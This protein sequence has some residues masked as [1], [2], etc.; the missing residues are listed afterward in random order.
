MNFRIVVMFLFLT[1][2]VD[3]GADLVQKEVRYQHDGTVMHGFIV[4]DDAIKTKRP[5]VLVVH[6]W[7]GHNNYARDRAIQ[8]AELGYTAF[9]VDMYGDGKTT[10]HPKSASKF[11]SAVS[12][13]MDLAK[14]R[15]ESAL[16]SLKQQE[17]VDSNNIAALGYCFGGGILLNLA[18][19]GIDIKGIA[20]FHGSVSTKK[21]A[22]KR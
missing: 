12:G 7:W 13:N 19:M 15:F 2:A 1:A 8:L 18:R 16:Y 6:E 10:D 4:F 5:G 14:A 17:S 9:A 20:S 22:K 21:P 3:A 11:S